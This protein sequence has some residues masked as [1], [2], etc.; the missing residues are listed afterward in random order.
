VGRNTEFERLFKRTDLTE[1]SAY[2]REV[3]QTIENLPTSALCHLAVIAVY[4]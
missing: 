4:G 1:A 3:R 2:A